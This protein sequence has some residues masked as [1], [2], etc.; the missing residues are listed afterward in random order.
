MP[1][2]LTRLF[3]V[4]ALFLFAAGAGAAPRWT[5]RIVCP[6]D[7]AGTPIEHGRADLME[8]LCSLGPRRVPSGMV[9]CVCCPGEFDNA[10]VK[11]A[12]KAL[13]RKPESFAIA[14]AGKDIA[15]VGFDR[16]GAMYG[17]FELAERI[18]LSGRAALDIRKPIAQ[19]PAV[20]FRAI[21]PF[22]T[23]PYK[24]T[25]SDWYFLQ[26][27]YW[28]GY[29]D[30]LARSRINWI[31][32]HGMFDIK[33][34]WFPNIYPYFITSDKFPKAGAEPRIAARNLAMLK[35]IMRWAKERGIK[36]GM[37]SYSTGWDETGLR[38]SPYPDTEENAAEYTREVVRKMIRSC[39]DLS[40]IGFRIGESGKDEDF[41]KTS[42]I[43][44]IEEAGRPIDLYTRTWGAKKESILQLGDAFP[45]RF[46]I[47][48]K[49]NGE[50]LGPPYII[51][52]GRARGWGDY[53]YQEYHSYPK[54][55]MVIYQLRANGTLRVF[56]WGNP[57]LT[58]R[59]NKEGLFGGAIG[60]CVEP[61]DTYYPK[62]DYRHK[63][64]YPNKWYKW[65]WQRDWFWYQSWGRTAYNPDLAARDD[66]WARMFAKRFG[67]A[68][69]S[70]L[71]NAMKWAS[72]IM[73][74]AHASYAMGIDH[75]AAAPELEWGGD[76]GEWADGQP[77]DLQN[78]QSPQEY[79]D[80][81]IKG[82]F[83]ARA[84]PITMSGYLEEEARMTRY[85]LDLARRKVSKPSAEFNDLAIELTMLSYLGDYYSHK[86]LA[87]A[88]FA[89]M[90]ASNDVKGCEYAGADRIREELQ[91]ARDAWNKLAGLGDKYYQPF[92]DKLRMNTEEYTWSKEGQNPAADF[93][94]LDNEVA[95]IRA[96]GK[97]SCLV[98][99]W[100]RGDA[101]GPDVADVSPR[102]EWLDPN[103][104]RKLT[105][106]VRVAD[107]SGVARVALKTKPFPSQSDWTAVDMQGTNGVYAASQTVASEG[108]IW[109]IEALDKDGNGTMWPDFRKETP[110]RAVEPWDVSSGRQRP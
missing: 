26:D 4:T 101:E 61:I 51:Q 62:Y 47:E 8:A 96:S 42:Y 9:F 10:A 77:F 2:K 75:R 87:A 73:P 28:K 16:T 84:T 94:A 93:E 100:S 29:L 35:R 85:H 13:P 107:P 72:R 24:E 14:R 11:A 53:F 22:I 64:D 63:A 37:M 49:F 33:S 39:P 43:P 83:S 90:K 105:V 104:I 92:V 71:L 3:V 40:M 54:N 25:D 32:L 19:S 46:L 78:I 69:A 86:L 108:L 76:V 18:G 110:Y 41:Y 34:T 20:G 44:A 27:D 55:Y 7:Y 56:P 82:E 88:F 23:L 52:G 70:D 30:L 48:I 12:S 98:N 21:N 95:A 5:P 31:D 80:R 109:C 79:A 99:V 45:H 89:V 74:D 106:T 66:I 15:V 36:F 60:L 6:E 65:Q 67:S 103:K 57:S 38:E 1:C 58:A 59:A 68:A 102:L 50:Q 81:L 97:E 91:L 17:C